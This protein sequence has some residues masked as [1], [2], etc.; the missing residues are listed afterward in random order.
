MNSQEKLARLRGILLEEWDP[1]ALAGVFDA[2]DEYDSYA[3]EIY[4]RQMER[5]WT[6]K[7]LFNYLVEVRTE[8]IGVDPDPDTDAETAQSILD[9]LAN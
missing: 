6:L 1:I 3:D 9:L 7:E 8:R 5:P 2:D 4:S